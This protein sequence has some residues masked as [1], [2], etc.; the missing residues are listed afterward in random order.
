M[1]SLLESVLIF[2]P[3]VF[4]FREIGRLIV[5]INFL[6][7]FIVGISLSGLILTPVIWSEVSWAQETQNSIFL[8]GLLLLLVRVYKNR[9][10]LLLNRGLLKRYWSK[11]TYFTLLYLFVGAFFINLSS[12]THVFSAHDV[13]YFGWLQEIWQASYSGGV[14]VPTLWPL[15][16]GSNNI[17]PGTVLSLI[18]TLQPDMNLVS[19]IDARYFLIVTTFFLVLKDLKLNTSSKMIKVFAALSISWLFFGAEIGAELNLSSYLYVLVLVV[20]IQLLLR[21]KL[22]IVG[23][24]M[25][26]LF[27]ILLVAKTQIA[28][29]ATV[30]IIVLIRRIGIKALN[31][32]I[33]SLWVLI[34]IN[35]LFWLIIPSTPGSNIGIPLPFGFH[36][37]IESGQLNLNLEKI[38]H[39]L[40]ILPGWYPAWEGGVVQNYS[41]GFVA[42]S[43]IFLL[44]SLKIYTVY[45]VAIRGVKIPRE[46]RNILDIF[47]GVSLFSW[48]VIRNGGHVGHQAHAFLTTSVVTAAVLAIVVFKFMKNS[49]ILPSLV[50]AITLNLYAGTLPPLNEVNADSIAQDYGM[51]IDDSK[52]LN[53]DEISLTQLQIWNSI[54][55]KK[56]PFDVNGD[57]TGSQASLFSQMNP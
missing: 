52:K 10:R 26:V 4:V 15:Q 21:K 51:T 1:R 41:S 3:S 27:S 47:V 9:T 20:I 28:L 55:G 49:F 16:L 22:E 5:K 57:Y 6:T 32:Q 46:N 11:I 23:I 53:P 44:I 48:V 24:P 50:I 38:Y 25:I 2:S 43:I 39:S 33:I 34:S 37:S 12:I 7:E 29:V 17:L 56:M 8:F 31:P 40:D 18:A 54:N 30:V 45:F 36:P 19:A 42:I 14:R 35:M 13:M